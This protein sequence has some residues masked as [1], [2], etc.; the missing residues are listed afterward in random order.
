MMF[1]LLSWERLLTGC[2]IDACRC[3]ITGSSMCPL[4]L[5]VSLDLKSTVPSP[6]HLVC[7]I[8]IYLFMPGGYSVCRLFTWDNGV[9]PSEKYLCRG[10]HMLPM[11]IIHD[12]IWLFSPENLH[13][14]VPSW[15]STHL[16]P[17]GFL[18]KEYMCYREMK[19]KLAFKISRTS[20]RID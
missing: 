9:P 16:L 19:R 2:L 3:P 1:H 11:L 13:P 12:H 10:A 15:D 18:L 4:L 7:S 8:S 20:E 5:L 14:Y 6:R 17:I